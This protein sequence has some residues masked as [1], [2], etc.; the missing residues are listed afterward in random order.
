MTNNVIFNKSDYK[1]LTTLLDKECFSEIASLSI[2]DIATFSELSIP[3]VRMTLKSF[4]LTD[5]VRL[6]AKD[7]VSN[8]YYITE[9]GL[10]FIN[11]ALGRG[12]E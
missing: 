10:D 7:G 2:K 11:K 9:K 8:T 4:L 6:G 1:I 5:L 12:G 3:K